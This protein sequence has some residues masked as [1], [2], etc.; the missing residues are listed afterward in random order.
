MGAAT[1]LRLLDLT[2]AADF[3]AVDA[4]TDWLADQC[5]QDHDAYRQVRDL[6]K[7]LVLGRKG[8][9]KTAIFRRLLRQHS[10]DP[11]SLRHLFDEY[12]SHH[13]ELQ[14]QSGVPEDRRY[15]HSWKYLILLSLSKVLLN[16]YHSQSWSADA[17]GSMAAL[18]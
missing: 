8:A 17:H 5:F 11:F 7:F 2:R 12:P 13:H 4:D 1:G 9:G 18:E 3:G 14:A 10:H 6:E 15:A 16:K